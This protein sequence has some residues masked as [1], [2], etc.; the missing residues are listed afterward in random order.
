MYIGLDIGTSGTK[1]ALID[2]RGRVL[3]GHHVNYGFS[4]TAD[5]YRELD[6]S[7]V[8]EAA[9]ECLREAAGAAA[10]GKQSGMIGGLSAAPEGAQAG[11]AVET[12]TVSSLGEAIV[13]ID[14]NGRPIGPGICGTDVRGEDELAELERRVG[15]RALTD[16]TGQNRSA[17]YSANKIMWLKKHRRELYDRAWKILNFQDFI[18]YNLCREAVMDYSI[19][20]RT[21]LFDIRT[22]DWSEALLE[23]SGISRGKLP[24][25]R[26][27]GTVVGTLTK[28]VA[29][30]TGLQRTVKIVTGTHDHVCNAI[31]SGVFEAGSCANTVGTTEGLTA[32]LRRE[33]LSPEHIEACRISCEPFA[34]QGL[35]NTVAWNNTSGVLLRWF[36]NEMVR[37]ES[38]DQI[39]ETFAKMN[40]QM[41]DAPTDLL[42]LPHFSGAATPYMDSASK[43]AIL[44]LTLDTKREDI[45]RALMEGANYELALILGKLEEAGLTPKKIVATGGALSGQLLQIKADIL[46]IDVHTV[47]NRQTGALGGAILGAVA[48]GRYADIR[49][50]AAEMIEEDR[51]Y[52]PR[53]AYFE[54]Y[55]ERLALYRKI[56]PAVCEINRGIGGKES[57]N[58]L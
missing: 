35:F 16:I 1:A 39:T 27:A 49:S 53:R 33:Q 50:A 29:A 44:G 8:W 11:A 6:A 25:V 32:V 30:E 28:S 10:G 57:R 3:G 5:G 38:P 41:K 42:V 58:K 19:A 2:D 47:K 51:V 23:A 46:G 52:E 13:P 18:I 20:C 12:I 45:Y 43:G 7:R 34:V 15:A 4:N 36:V 26:P 9:K 22:F 55:Q 14:V 24:D 48:A 56:Y 40:A 54:A 17:I 37:E 21:L 31:G